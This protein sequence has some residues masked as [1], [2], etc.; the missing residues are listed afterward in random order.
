LPP[1]N[2]SGV[3]ICES[4]ILRDRFIGR[5]SIG[6]SDLTGCPEM[7]AF[8]MKNQKLTACAACSVL[9]VYA[10]FCMVFSTP[11]T[12]REEG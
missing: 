11:L 12:W 4:N 10:R 8:V 7:S 2:A 9:L 6:W 1:D 5:Y 3:C